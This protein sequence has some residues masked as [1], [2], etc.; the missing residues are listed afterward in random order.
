MCR[1]ISEKTGVHIRRNSACSQR[2]SFAILSLG[3]RFTMT[4]QP[5]QDQKIIAAGIL[6]QRYLDS[7]SPE[8][9]RVREQLVQEC[10]LPLIRTTLRRKLG[11]DIAGSSGLQGTREELALEV[12]GKVLIALLRQME[13]WH[14]GEAV[15]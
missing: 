10:L 7:A 1:V 5:D 8:L 13:R 15:A 3:A 14:T 12:Y 4:L 6:L 9:E 2:M 11:A